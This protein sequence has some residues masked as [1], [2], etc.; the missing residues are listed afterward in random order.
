[1]NETQMKDKKDQ[2]VT[3]R[4]WDIKNETIQIWN[5]HRRKKILSM[6]QRIEQNTT[7]RMQEAYAKSSESV[8]NL[9]NWMRQTQRNDVNVW[10]H[11]H[12]ILQLLSGK[13]EPEPNKG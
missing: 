9:T 12:V 13:G 11:S 8:K 5:D 4:K 1:M 6:K 2:V 3:R 10:D 7:R